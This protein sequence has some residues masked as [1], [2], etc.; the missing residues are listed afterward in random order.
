MIVFVLK[1]LLGKVVGLDRIPK[2]KREIFWQ[3]LAAFSVKL[4]GEMAEGAARGAVEGS[5]RGSR[6]A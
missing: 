3:Q 5:N 2:E 4:A 1:S 6:V